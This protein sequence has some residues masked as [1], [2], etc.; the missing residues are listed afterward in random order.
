MKKSELEQLIWEIV[1]VEVIGD[2]GRPDEDYE[3]LVTA[4]TIGAGALVLL[5]KKK[6]YVAKTGRA[7]TDGFE[8]VISIEDLIKLV[9]GEADE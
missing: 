5:A 9:E 2:M 1:A 7:G 4:A 6:S 8:R 3:P